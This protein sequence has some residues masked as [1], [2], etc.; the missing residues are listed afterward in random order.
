MRSADPEG[1]WLRHAPRAAGDRL[2]RGLSTGPTSRLVSVK[3]N[4][5]ERVTPDGIQTADGTVHELDVI[6]PRHRL[7]RRHRRAHPH[8]HPR[9]RRPL[10]EG[11]LGHGTSAPPWACRCTATPTCSPPPSPL[12]P[13]A[14]LCN[15]TTCLQQQ[16]EWI[17][18]CIRHLRGTSMHGDR[19]DPG[20]SRTAWVDHHETTAA[21]TLDHQDQLMVHGLERDGQTAPGA[22]LHRRGRHLPQEMRPRLPRAGY[23]GF[24]MQLSDAGLA[25]GSA[26]PAAEPAFA[27][28][29]REGRHGAGFH[30]GRR[31][32]PAA[33]S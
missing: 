2:P 13:S 14:A 28:A 15:M 5:I 31:R 26:A 30:L 27:H 33:P 18:D 21:A 19:A 22:L 32:D 29:T 16:T 20:D 12:A 25:A 7:R 24:A 11:G 10:A 3:D 23:P 4:P 17:S 9:P 6:D 8:R 1:L